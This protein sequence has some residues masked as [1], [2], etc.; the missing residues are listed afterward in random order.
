MQGISNFE[1]REIFNFQCSIF[2]VHLKKGK[3]ACPAN[4]GGKIEN[5]KGKNHTNSKYTNSNHSLSFYLPT[6][7]HEK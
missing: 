3:N 4:G 7:K 6:I 5:V 2:N 1:G